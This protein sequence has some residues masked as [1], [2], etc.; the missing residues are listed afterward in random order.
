MAPLTIHGNLFEPD[1]GK[2]ASAAATTNFIIV[3]TKAALT[4]SDRISLQH[5]RAIYQREIAEYTYLFRYDPADL[6]IL[7]ELP[8]VKFVDIYHPHLKLSSAFE[9]I[10]IPESS[11]PTDE[12]SQTLAGASPATMAN[13]PAASPADHI[14]I[15][16]S[17][18]NDAKETASDIANRLVQSGIISMDTT[19]IISPIR[20]DTKVAPANLNKIAALDSVSTIDP[21][22]KKSRSIDVS[23]TLLTDC[24]YSPDMSTE[25][26]G[27]GQVIAVA[28]SGFD[29]GLTTNVHPAFLPGSV[30][31]ISNVFGP[32]EPL[33][34]TDGHGT[35][36]CGCITL[37]TT[38]ANMA[39][40]RRVR[41]AAGGAKLVVVRDESAAGAIW[42]TSGVAGFF[43]TPYLG[44]HAPRVFNRSVNSLSPGQ[45]YD[46]EAGDIDE[47]TFKYQSAFVCLSAGNMGAP[48]V[49]TQIGEDTAAKN[50]TVVGS[51]DSTRP[52]NGAVYDPTK[53][54]DNDH[55]FVNVFSN[56]GPTPEGRFKPDLVAPGT[57]ILS[58]LS[59]EATD[60]H[61]YGISTD[62][63]LMFGSGTSQAAP[64]VAGCAAVIR[65]A[66]I[67]RPTSPVLTPSG[68][69]VKALLIN[70][71]VPL[72]PN[73]VVPNNESGFG[74]VNVFGS[75]AHLEI[76]NPPAK[77]RGG[78]FS[79]TITAGASIT[80]VN[81]EVPASETVL[82]TGD[83]IPHRLR[84]TL[85]WYDIR[86][87]ATENK[88][89]LTVKKS[90][91]TAAQAVCGNR[92]ISAA[93][94]RAPDLLN[95]V[96]RVDWVDIPSG[97]YIADVTCNV[98]APAG[99]SVEFHVAWYVF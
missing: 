63:N 62:T 26:T 56:R 9:H 98:T 50:L 31:D 61:K 91:G 7:R 71:A 24:V 48:G 16:L 67:K 85:V 5:L 21:Y 29:K 28:D 79:G 13:V 84:V 14:W 53:P 8:F 96:Q 83:V 72:N 60:S 95:T 35:H 70:G 92:D 81:I 38:S 1:A 82:L 3:H 37:S 69:L 36:V 15:A 4:P 32:G 22:G 10:E 87:S 88:L 86:G 52:N 89:Y 49:T 33:K 44:A 40:G 41:G 34:D 17:L 94:G 76:P 80:A 43:E 65:E 55:Y 77:P 2:A 19:R 42:P 68:A 75:L 25:Y 47:F 45:P 93:D 30:L 39:G 6:N 54:T 99:N 58:A 51:C 11:L 78:F 46:G 57:A 18:H 59:R 27:K 64:A 20:M 90:G 23:R 12:D 97:D 66:L 74:R 73:T